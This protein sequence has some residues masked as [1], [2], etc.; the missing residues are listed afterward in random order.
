MQRLECRLFPF[1]PTPK[2]AGDVQR[3]DIVGIVDGGN[4]GR[5]RWSVGMQAVRGL[6]VAVDGR[7]TP[8]P[9]FHKLVSVN[10]SGARFAMVLRWDQGGVA[11]CEAALD[12]ASN[13]QTVVD[14]QSSS[15]LSHVSTCLAAGCIMGISPSPC[16]A[17]HRIAY[18]V[19]GLF[20]LYSAP[21]S[22]L[23]LLSDADAS[24]RLHWRSR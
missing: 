6:T 1:F 20:A 4:R 14:D 12:G 16:T 24:S 13:S 19:A 9:T 22:R 17:S 10:S 23:P 21:S 15:H 18:G 7:V 3:D 11:C 5:E 2:T 8:A